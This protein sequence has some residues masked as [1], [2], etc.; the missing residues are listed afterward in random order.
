MAEDGKKGVLCISIDLELA[1]GIWDK[2]DQETFNRIRKLERHIVRRLLAIFSQ[3]E[4]SAT[5][6]IVG[7]L[8]ERRSS[9]GSSFD[10][11]IWYAPD[12]LEDIHNVSPRQEVGSHGFS[13]KYYNELSKEEALEDLERSRIIHQAHGLNWGSFVFPRNFPNHLDL[14]TES[15]IQIY[16]G[17]DSG[18]LIDAGRMMGRKVLRLMNLADK[19][20][21]IQPRT[22]TPTSKINGLL[23]LPGSM[24]WF[25]RQG[26]RRI[27]HPR[28]LEAK[29][30]LG[31]RRAAARGE[32][33]SLW[34]HPS[35]FYYDTENMLGYFERAMNR[36]ARMRTSGQIEILPMGRLGK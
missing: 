18:L 23:E 21:P 25:S 24:L 33:F 31:L 29:V 9:A 7:H 11:E 5:W 32:I 17:K 30:A 13:H 12:L 35:N 3:N 14:L 2:P 36:A 6:A 22:F 10:E 27:I 8:L 26:I 15:G 1:W 34:F 20:L 28:N 19:T 4:I 16:R